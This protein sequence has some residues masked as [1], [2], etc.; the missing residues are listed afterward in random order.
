VVQFRHTC[1]TVH[2]TVRYGTVTRAV[3][4][5]SARAGLGPKLSHIIMHY[6]SVMIMNSCII[7]IMS[8]FMEDNFLGKFYFYIFNLKLLTDN[9]IYYVN[10]IN[11][12][13]G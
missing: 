13:N 5:D 3:I 1:E 11:N 10:N 8:L 4:C 12:I 7:L 2:S 9:N 6:S